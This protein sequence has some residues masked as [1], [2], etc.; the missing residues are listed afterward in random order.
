MSVLELSI[1]EVP[2]KS[3]NILKFVPELLDYIDK[4]DTYLAVV[5]NKNGALLREEIEFLKWNNLFSR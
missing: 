5:S 3:T 4:E 2:P 1:V